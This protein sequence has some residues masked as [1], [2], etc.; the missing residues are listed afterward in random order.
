MADG[1]AA[2]EARAAAGTAVPGGP[3]AKRRSTLGDI[4]GHAVAVPGRRAEA[5]ATLTLP[6]VSPNGDG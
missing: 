1:A 2:R 4:R 5:A 6:G 3:R